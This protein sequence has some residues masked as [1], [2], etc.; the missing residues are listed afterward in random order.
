MSGTKK[1]ALVAMAALLTLG[2]I[3]AAANSADPGVAHAHEW[4]C[5]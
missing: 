3:T 4:V 1:L 5:C 2:G